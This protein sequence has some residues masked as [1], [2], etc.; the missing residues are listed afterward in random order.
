MMTHLIQFRVCDFFQ[1][2]KI[3]GEGSFG[4]VYGAFHVLTGAEVAIKVEMPPENGA[5]AILP[6]EAAVYKHLHG[7]AG[8]PSILWNGM[9]GGAHVMIMERLG[10]NLEQLRRFCRGQLSLKTVCMLAEQMIT[11]IEFAHSR[12]V[13]IR[14]VKPEHFAMGMGPHSNL[15]FLFDL[16]LAKMIFDPSTSAHIPRRDGREGFGTP[17]YV[18]ANVHL[19]I[20]QSRRDDIYAL[21]HTL[22][23][24]FHGKLPWQGIYAPSVPDKLSLIGKMKA[25]EALS[26]LISRS[27][28][29][30]MAYFNHCRALKFDEL[31]DYKMLR[32]VFRE[33]MKREDWTYD[34]KYDWLTPSELEKRTLLPEE[35]KFDEQYTKDDLMTFL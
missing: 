33:R 17:R 31:P 25:G 2:T 34:W 7:H 16:G 13:I 35:Y 19:G 1:V 21:G 24:L 3:I 14:D 26:E 20:E 23:Y 32:G 8:I 5:H 28:P 30:F 10:A 12:G 6:Y 4:Q 9:D 22:L 18:S 29:E 11:R 15:V 27:P